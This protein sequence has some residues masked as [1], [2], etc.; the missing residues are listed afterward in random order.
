MRRHGTVDDDAEAVDMGDVGFVLL[1]GGKG[2]R[3]KA[4]MPKQFLELLRVPIL[5]HSLDLFLER[6]PAFLSSKGIAAPP[7]VVLVMDPSYQPEYQPIVDRYAG[8]LVFA[9]PGI[10][11]QG[12]V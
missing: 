4:G 12:S 9:N 2:S 10:E 8:R 7:F 1:A 5:H 11:R 3:M 6:L